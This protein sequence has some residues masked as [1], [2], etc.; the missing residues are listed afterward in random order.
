MRSATSSRW[1][2]GVA[3]AVAGIAFACTAQAAAVLSSY[4]GTVRVATPDNKVAQG[5][6]NQP[7][8]PGSAVVTEDGARA[9]LKFDDGQ[10][11]VLGQDTR[12]KLDD[13][14]FDAAH[15]GD[16]RVVMDLLG[17]A[18]RV[19]TGRIGSSDPEQFALRVPQATIRAH[20]AD[21][22]I[23]VTGSAACLSVIRGSVSA[24]NDA[25]TTRFGAGSNGLIASA[26]AQAAVVP[27]SAL[28][29]EASKAFGDLR[30]VPGVAARG[31]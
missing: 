30:A 14:Q 28:P 27:D 20:G 13:F 18:L 31:S 16:G 26:H 6:E 10:V 9:I 8:A 4:Q 3:A 21:F 19:R 25:G 29:P 22:M 5:Q 15:P 24:T 12:F 2:V 1:L 17:G 23:S 7:I 11:V